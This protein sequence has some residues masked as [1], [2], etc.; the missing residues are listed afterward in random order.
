[1]K[2]LFMKILIT[3]SRGYIGYNLIQYLQRHAPEIELIGLDSTFKELSKKSKDKLRHDHILD[4]LH[5]DDTIL[6]AELPLDVT[7]VIHL[8]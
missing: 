8:A 1:M 7:H 2:E 3:G 4:I 6:E 5:I